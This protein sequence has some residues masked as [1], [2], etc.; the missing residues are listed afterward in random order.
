MKLVD[1][2]EF[3][4]ERGGGVR[5]YT[6]AKLAAGARLGVEVVIVAPGD[7][8]REERREGGRVIW[9][10]SPR[11]ALDPRYHVLLRERAVHAILDAESPDVVEGSSTWTGGAFVARWRG[12]AARSLVFHQD[13]VA[14]YPH[15][16]LD[17]AVAPARLDR[18]A[19]PWWAYLRR[20][21]G[22]FDLTVVAGEW[23]AERLREQRVANAIAVPFGITKHGATNASAAIDRDLVG[24]AAATTADDAHTEETSR[25][26]RELLR[27]AGAP[28]DAT[29]L[30]AISR[31]HPE[32]RLGTVL[33][34]V[35][36]ANERQRAR[37]L[38]GVALALFGDGPLRALVEH[39]AR[40]HGPTF[41]AGFTSDR[42]RLRA[43]LANADAFVHGSAAE[44]Y[45][46]VVAEA[47][48]A[49]LPLVVPSRGGAAD[50]ADPAWAE[51]YAPGDPVAC[52]DAIE[53]LLVRD[54]DGLRAAARHAAST[55]VRDLDDHFADLFA[56]YSSVSRT[57]TRK[58]DCDAPRA[59]DTRP[60][61][62]IGHRAIDARDQDEAPTPEA[63]T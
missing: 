60:I 52:A 39:D 32:K 30:V 43:A 26:R 10:K 45:G 18:L 46:L 53:R 3:Y 15:S 6:H 22:A 51:T 44:T 14:V 13:P 40:R 29:L 49:G 28:D 16:L 1:V 27:R 12:A 11:L 56:R 62:S 63:R 47:L 34:G 23:L 36:R 37:G 59:T 17:R 38:P 2:S 31:H 55:R 33:R 5:T 58:R 9:V 25:V 21:A 48:D 57:R 8:D 50:L 41:V 7:A 19:W 4:A 35:S 54:R 61:R 20:L 24:S 42:A